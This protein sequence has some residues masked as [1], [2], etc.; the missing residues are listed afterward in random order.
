MTRQE[1]ED[2]L[3]EEV[4]DVATGLLIEAGFGG[5]KKGQLYGE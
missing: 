2:E 1:L 4:K 5:M 3:K